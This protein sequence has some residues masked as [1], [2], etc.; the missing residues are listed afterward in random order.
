MSECLSLIY[1]LSLGTTPTT[2]PQNKKRK[3]LLIQNLSGNTV[4][5]AKTD[6]LD[7][8][9]ALQL[10][11]GNIYENQDYAQDELKLWAT[12]AA[13]LVRIEEDCQK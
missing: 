2:L 10:D 12:V 11:S 6:N 7:T 8:N 13:S 9:Q 3:A 5:I 1:S 4:Y